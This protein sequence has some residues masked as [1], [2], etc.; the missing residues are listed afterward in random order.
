MADFALTVLSSGS[1]GNLVHLACGATQVFVD[2]GLSCKEACA[3][4]F[5]AGLDPAQVGAIFVSHEHIDHIRGISV[6]SRRFKVPVYIAPRA[7]A[8]CQAEHPDWYETHLITAG[9]EIEVGG[10][11]VLPLGI[12]HDA[13][14]PLGF[15]FRRG[16]QCVATATDL[17]YVPE[18]VCQALG[19]AQLLLIESNHDEQMLR[20]GPYPGYLKNRISSNRG[21]LSNKQC[22]DLLARLPQG[23]LRAVVLAHLSEE[24]NTPDLARQSAA[25][26]LA[27]QHPQAALYVASQ[28]H[29][30]PTL[31]LE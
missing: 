21:H 2:F 17:G 3:R 10:L 13:A 7:R 6:F 31:R 24:N 4:C 19:A 20:D 28:A 29:P 5:S 27:A 23:T 14:E 16:A 30:L 11:S 12:S 1:R 15:V 8:A 9:V 18:S 25:K 26:V 22:A